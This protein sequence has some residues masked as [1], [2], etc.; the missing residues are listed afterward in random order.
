[1]RKL[2]RTR[3]QN[4]LDCPKCFYLEEIFKIK[5]PSMAPFLINSA[6]D[7]LLKKE[8]DFYRENKKPHPY[9]S[10]VGLDAIPAQHVKLNTWRN[11]FQ[12]VQYILKEKNTLLFGGI[13]DLWINSDGEYIVVDYKATAKNDAPTLDGKWGKK[14][15]N[16]IEF[17][18][19]LLRR[20][21][22]KVSNSSFFDLLPQFDHLIF[23]KSL[24]LGMLRV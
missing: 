13:D 22:L 19:W 8:F 1:M 15:R 14:Y 23:L 2:S 20:N 18:Q 3:I 12:G 5:K 7:L 16:Q 21:D 6:V 9:I 10:Q 24:I 4:F 11:V 17:Y